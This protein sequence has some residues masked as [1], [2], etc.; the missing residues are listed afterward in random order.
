MRIRNVPKAENV[1]KDFSQSCGMKTL[2]LIYG[3]QSTL[4]R[5][6]TRVKPMIFL[7]LRELL[8][9]FRD[10]FLSLI[11][12]TVFKVNMENA[13]YGSIPGS[14]LLLFFI[15][16]YTPKFLQLL[17]TIEDQKMKAERYI[18]QSVYLFLKCF[19]ISIHLSYSIHRIINSMKSN[20]SRDSKCLFQRSWFQSR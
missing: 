16:C 2:L 13:C 7:S 1:L 10:I 9:V 18:M 4:G 8:S 5:T 19:R 15:I 3:R 14:L 11:F 12:I 6:L 20:F 17:T